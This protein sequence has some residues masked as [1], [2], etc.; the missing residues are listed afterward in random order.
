MRCG[1]GRRLCYVGREV[2]NTVATSQQMGF[3]SPTEDTNIPGVA[4]ST[5]TS[6]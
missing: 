5:K 4:I 2:E 3:D 1:T 6:A